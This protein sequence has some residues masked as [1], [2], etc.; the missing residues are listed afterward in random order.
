MKDNSKFLV[1]Q[2]AFLGDVVLATPIIEKLHRFYPSAQIDIVVRKGNEGLLNDHPI[3]NTVHVFDKS[4]GKYKNLLA[5]A[6]TLRKEKYTQV[7]N[8]QRFATTGLLTALSGGKERI[9]FDKNPF[10]FLY[11]KKI[12]HHIGDVQ[13]SHEI[14][15]NLKLIEDLTDDS[16]QAPKLYPSAADFDKTKQS[17]PYITLAPASVWFTK[18]WPIEKWVELADALPAELNILLIGAPGDIT[19]CETIKGQIKRSDVH[20]MAGKFNLLQSA[21]LMK[22]AKLNFTNDSAPAHLASAMN[23]P[24]AE[25]YCS[26]VPEF[27]FG[28]VAQES[29]TIEV[30]EKLSCRPCGLH[31]KKA[32]PL[33]HFKCADV[34]I[35]AIL[36]QTGL[37]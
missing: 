8:L 5:L 6:K 22:G 4:K 26:T 11:S 29:Y 17:K 37:A 10:S 32:C 35:D 1:I 19:L 30:K 16:W 18:Q 13:T 34:S 33:G 20:N 25:I 2:T 7:I 28:P 21:A 12:K 3:L 23:A 14:E 24:V 36:T 9:G 31:G 27:G 15:R